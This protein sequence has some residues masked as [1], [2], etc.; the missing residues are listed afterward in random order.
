MCGWSGDHLGHCNQECLTEQTM[1]GWSGH[2][3]SI[4]GY[5]DR[6]C[7]AEQTMTGWSGDPFGIPQD[8]DQECLAERTMGQD[9]IGSRKRSRGGSQ[10]RENGFAEKR[11]KQ[12]SIL[13]GATM[14]RSPTI[15]LE[16]ASPE[17][18]L[19]KEPIAF[20][21]PF[22]KYNSQKHQ[23]CLRYELRRVKDVKQHIYRKHTQ[24]EFYCARCFEKFSTAESRDRHTVEPSCIRKEEIQFDGISS[25]QRKSLNSY[26]NRTQSAQDQWFSTWDIIFPDK[27]RPSTCFVGNYAEEITSQLRDFWGQKQAEILSSVLGETSIDGISPNLLDKVIGRLF[28][29]FESALFSSAPKMDTMQSLATALTTQRRIEPADRK[30]KQLCQESRSTETSEHWTQVWPVNQSLPLDNTCY[31]SP[32]GTA[33]EGTENWGT[34]FSTI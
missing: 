33:G 20:A 25:S 15:E 6:D 16:S 7:L 30:D 5:S 32:F 12:Q 24:P 2:R 27:S 17:I 34:G 29:R 28:D 3:L 23:E 21:C 13:R 26:V 18:N 14:N 19:R 31:E 11:T 22:Y 8:Y 10:G 9:S 4:L 1:P